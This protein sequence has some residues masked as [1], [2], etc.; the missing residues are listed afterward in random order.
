MTTD[1]NADL[2]ENFVQL[3]RLAHDSFN[4]RRSYEWKIHFGLWAAIAAVVFAAKKE[5]IVIF[6]NPAIAWTIGVAIWLLY[7]LHFAMVSCG[8]W[9]DKKRKHYFMAKAEGKQN[10]TMEKYSK[11][12]FGA[13]LLWAIPYMSFT[14][15][16]ICLAITILLAIQ[17]PLVVAG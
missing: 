2:K 4:Q 14:G 10:V 9:Q 16:L 7:A 1:N 6:T 12:K 11:G 13:Q 17:S 5:H 8:H 3:A 15:F